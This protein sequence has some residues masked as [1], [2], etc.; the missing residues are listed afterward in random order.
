[1]ASVKKAKKGVVTAGPDFGR[2]N[3]L[4]L[5]VG[6]IL[7]VVGFLFLAGGDITIAPILLV[8]GYCVVIPLGILYPKG[9]DDASRLEIEKNSAV[10]S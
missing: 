9:K 3:Y 8:L 2:K 1:M 4:I 5:G 6:L 7:I 10:S